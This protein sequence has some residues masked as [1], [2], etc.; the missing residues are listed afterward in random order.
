M[1]TMGSREYGR[2]FILWLAL[3]TL[4]AADAGRAGAST[5]PEGIVEGDAL[6]KKGS[7]EEAER[8]FR[9]ALERDPSSKDAK[10]GLA[11]TWA[12]VGLA[13]LKEE[14]LFAAVNFA[15]KAVELYPE[16]IEF[17][18][19]LAR[20][21]FRQ[22]N[23]YYAGNVL[24]RALELD[25]GNIDGLV[26]LGDIYYQEGLL[27]EALSQ[28]EKVP[29]D[30]PQGRALER[31]IG[32][33]RA[34]LAVE[35]NLEREVSRNFT[36]LFDSPVPKSEILLLL[37]QLERTYRDLSRELGSS[38]P[39]D[40]LVILY[41]RVDF[42]RITTGPLWKGGI[43]DGKI[44]V[45]VGGLSTERYA[46]TLDPVLRHELT[47]AF[48]RSMVE[49]RLPPW[50]EEGL[51]MYF[52]GPAGREERKMMGI[53]HD[54]TFASFKHIN[55]AIRGRDAVVA[56]AY[57]AAADAVEFLIRERGFPAIRNVLNEMAEG[58]SFHLALEEETG[59]TAQELYDI[60]RE[61]EA[62]RDSDD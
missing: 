18:F 33:S 7:Y 3:A 13:A 10:R 53:D 51:A 61:K 45:P 50:F 25:P 43:Y 35:K 20:A 9:E 44:R 12:E 27:G 14:N 31:K 11:R 40:I 6:L 46:A 39:G 34:E 24:E 28:W 1:I 2:L 8:K 5:V 15:E 47:H 21:L 16:E 30:S 48:L 36:L 41:S 49:R 29:Q 56:L 57:L 59:L 55:N 19:L 42:Q 37:D 52:E 62:G 58:T 38:P 22:K 17:H 26:L 60:W 4:P 54:G 23:Y 32:N